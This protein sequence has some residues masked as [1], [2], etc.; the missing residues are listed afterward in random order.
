MLAY[1]TNKY[2]SESCLIQWATANPFSLIS[3][4]NF[5]PVNKGAKGKIHHDLT[6]LMTDTHTPI[7]ISGNLTL[8]HPK[9]SKRWIA[10]SG[11][12]VKYGFNT[13]PSYSDVQDSRTELY[14]K[15]IAP[16][17]RL[18]V[19]VFIHLNDLILVPVAMKV[20]PMYLLWNY[21]VHPPSDLLLLKLS[22]YLPHMYFR[23]TAC[24]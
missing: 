11:Q 18:I 23:G 7:L 12:F 22:R 8:L 19:V 1:A 24:I 20:D 15:S 3:L 6:L 16:A 9:S 17:T 13:F 5:C 2:F 10:T 21:D 14:R 4:C